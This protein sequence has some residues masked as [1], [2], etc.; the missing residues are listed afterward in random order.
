MPE[1]DPLTV[2]MRLFLQANHQPFVVQIESV[3]QCL[4]DA[5][6][7]HPQFWNILDFFKCHIDTRAVKLNNMAFEASNLD[8]LHALTISYC[9]LLI[10]A[11][12][13]KQSFI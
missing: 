11:L 10:D 12:D 7:I 13:I 2:L 1:M 6:Q 4:A 9:D 3:L 8:C 5:E